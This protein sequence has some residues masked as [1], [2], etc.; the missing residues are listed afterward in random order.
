MKSLFRSFAL[1]SIVCAG[2]ATAPLAYAQA[3]SYPDRPIRIVVPFSSGGIVDTIARLVGEKLSTRYNQP[4]IVENKTG[5]GGAIGTDFAAKAAPDGYTLLFVSPGHAVAPSLLKSVTWSPVRDFRAI[6]GF[7][8]ISNVFVVHPDLPVRNMSELIAL[9]KKSPAPLTYGTAGNGTSNHLSGELLGQ[10]ADIKLTQVTYKG[11]PDAMSDL[12]SGRI[13]M[14]SLTSALAIGHI[15][16]GKLR[17]LAV[18]T[19]KRSSALPDVPTVAEAANLPDYDVGTWFG[20]VTQAQVPEAI[21]RKLSAD[22]SEIMQ[23]PEVKTKL[24]VLGLDSNPQG[25]AEF[26]AFVARE[27]TKWSRVIKQAGIVPQ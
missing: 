24:E 13:S 15:K 6:Q 2:A 10:M 16:S 12:L 23:M 7:G 8:V 22:I 21:V 19:A 14:M 1:A 9:A 18:T 27:F 25:P 11:Q 20:V 4:V 17:A 5:A 3:E 26:D